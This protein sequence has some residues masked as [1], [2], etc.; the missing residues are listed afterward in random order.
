MMAVFINGL[1]TVV[2]YG[3]MMLAAHRGIYG[4]GLLLTLGTAA[5]LVASLVVL[6]VLLRE[7]GGRSTPRPLP[8][9]ATPE[10]APS[11][12]PS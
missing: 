4:L 5:S 9:A 6:P 8:I 11:P 7:F 10:P 2:G 12:T 3:S 1:T